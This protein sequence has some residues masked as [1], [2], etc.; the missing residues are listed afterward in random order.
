M[1]TMLP[2]YCDVL[3]LAAGTVPPYLKFKDLNTAIFCESDCS[4][5]SLSS[6]YIEP[7]SRSNE[8]ATSRSLLTFCPVIAT[9]S[10]I[11][12]TGYVV[13]M[14]FEETVLKSTTF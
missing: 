9:F 3:E 14:A 8:F 4:S 13:Y 5:I 12:I 2:Y 11:F 1:L 7:I 10:Q 6:F